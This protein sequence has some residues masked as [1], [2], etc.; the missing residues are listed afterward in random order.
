MSPKSRR[1]TIIVATL[2]AACAPPTST[3]GVDALFVSTP[4]AIVACGDNAGE[5]DAR[6]WISGQ[7]APCGL[8]VDVGAG[9]TAGEC[10]V[11]PGTVRKLTIDW[12]LPLGRA[13]GLDLVLAQFRGDLDLTQAAEDTAT[14]AIEE[15]NIQTQSCLDMRDDQFNGASDV[16]LDPGATAVPVCDLDASGAFNV[17]EVCA[18]ADA[19]DA[20]VEP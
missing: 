13:D 4:Q 16:S 1:A 12:F 9:T 18:G 14:F 20:A 15:A 3:S 19:L 5:L 6:M 2:M 7:S 11:A 10:S 17:D 8:T